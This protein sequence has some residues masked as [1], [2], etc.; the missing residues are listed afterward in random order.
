MDENNAESTLE[1]LIGRL[2]PPPLRIHHIMAATAVTAVLA[3]PLPV[4]VEALSR[5]DRADVLL[6]HLPDVPELVHGHL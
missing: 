1:S 3:E 6:A 4:V 2:G 5:Y